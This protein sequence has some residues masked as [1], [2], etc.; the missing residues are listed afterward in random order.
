MEYYL[1]LL[2]RAVF[3]ENLA[4]VFFLGMCTF[5]AISKKIETALGLG[6]AVTVVQTI[7]VPVNNL[8]FEY[9]LADGALAWAG[10]GQVN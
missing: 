6:I 2:I 5:I 1:S 7:T 4:L 8:I 3:I 9:L 10:L